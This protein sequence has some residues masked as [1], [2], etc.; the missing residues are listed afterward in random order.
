MDSV[1]YHSLL[2]LLTVIGLILI[3]GFFT[4]IHT[5]VISLSQDKLRDL[6]EEGSKEAEVLIKIT[7]N[8][9]RLNQSFAMINSVISLVTVAFIADMIRDSAFIMD[10]FSMKTA[11]LIT[12]LLYIVVKIIFVDKIPQRIGVRNPLAFAL[13]T[14]G[15]LRVRDRKSVV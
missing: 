15:I 1:P 3:N 11:L 10:N 4:A 6:R 2:L 5:G 9:D 8:Q 13:N 7:S 14:T 12:I